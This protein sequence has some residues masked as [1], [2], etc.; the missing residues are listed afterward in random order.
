MST[1]NRPGALFGR[2]VY[3]LFFWGGLGQPVGRSAA[4]VCSRSISSYV[5]KF[6]GCVQHIESPCVYCT[7]FEFSREP[8]ASA[9][10][11]DN[12]NLSPT[13]SRRVITCI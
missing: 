1:P 7:P 3:F 6:L 2:S 8:P 4:L 13:C 10:Y 9:E 5:L 12:P 11:V